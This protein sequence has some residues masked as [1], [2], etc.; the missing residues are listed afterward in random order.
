[1]AAAAILRKA[2]MDIDYVVQIWRDGTQFIAHAMPVD[3]ASFG[4]TPQA[5]RSAVDEAVRLFIKTAEEHGTLAQVLE[6]AGYR[7]DGSRWQ[8][9]DWI[10]IEKHSAPVAA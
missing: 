4:G 8:S 7:F 6:D 3:V 1:M 5:A 2:L 9:P 10:G